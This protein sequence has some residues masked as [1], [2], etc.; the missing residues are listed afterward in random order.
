[1]KQKICLK[2]LN[3]LLIKPSTNDNMQLTATFAASLMSRGFTLSK[4]LYTA[5]K[6]LSTEELTKLHR[7]VMATIKQMKGDVKHPIMYPNFP[8]QVMEM[9]YLE[10]F[11]NAIIHYWSSGHWLPEYEKL[12][13]EFAFEK[14]DFQELDLVTED[15][16]QIVFAQLVGSNESLSDEDKKIVEW[17][18]ENESNLILPE[19]IPFKENMCLVAGM[20]L[21]TGKNIDNLV[22][23]ATDLLRL[24]TY[25]N[26]GDVSLAENCKF[27]SMPRSQRKMFSQLLEKVASEEDINRHRNKWVRLFHCLHIG[28]YSSPMYEIAK[29]LRNNKRIETFNSRVEAAIAQCRTA[30]TSQNVEKAVVL[31]HQRPGEFARRLD[32]FLRLVDKSAQNL[33]VS[34]F[35]KVADQ[36]PT[37]IVAQLLGHFHNRQTQTGQYTG[38]RIIFPKGNTQRARSIAPPDGSVDSKILTTLF[39]GLELTLKNHFKALPALGKVWIDP[40]LKQCPIPTQQRSASVGLFNVARGTRLPFGDVSK[41]T[42]RFFVHWIGQDLDLSATLHDEDFKLVEQISYTHLKSHDFQAWHSGDIVY[43]PPPNGGTEM[44]DITIDAAAKRARYVVMNVFVFRGPTFA[45]HE[46]CFAGWMT[47]SAPKSNE[48]FD[49]K[50]VEQKIDIRAASKNIIPAVF[51]LVERKM[52]W[53]DLSTKNR[54]YSYGSYYRGNNVHNNQATIEQTLRNIV[55]ANNKLSLFDLFRYHAEVRGELVE[56]KEE[57]ETVFSLEDGVTPFDINIITSEY[58]VP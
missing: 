53:C 25:L 50:T 51:D 26:G 24:V 39:D 41:N 15:Q 9:S 3:G 17:F 56:T 57:A 7:D 23:T 42:L 44:I 12:P 33:I 5:L 6:T 1:M 2:K 55:E 20:F 58:L 36:L 28:D 38:Q 14:I 13:R 16:F 8:Q 40:Q 49:P 30:P 22:K 18:L 35:L 54:N 11:I 21:K 48:V 32:H 45:E 46:T 37:R 52:I 19:N 34:E 31:L 10:L 4:S 29:K 47:R 43:A 27:K